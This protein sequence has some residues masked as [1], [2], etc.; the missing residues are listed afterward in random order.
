MT[1][2]TGLGEDFWDRITVAGPPA[3]YSRVRI[4]KTGQLGHVSLDGLAGKVS[5]DR[6]DWRGQNIKEKL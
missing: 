1:A 2:K 6:S 4:V 5:V 3:Q